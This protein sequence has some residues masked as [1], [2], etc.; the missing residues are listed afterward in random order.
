MAPI[1]MKDCLD[2]SSCVTDLQFILVHHFHPLR[3][4]EIEVFY[5]FILQ[6]KWFELGNGVQPFELVSKA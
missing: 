4:G 5:L 1:N 6:A 3:A 2:P